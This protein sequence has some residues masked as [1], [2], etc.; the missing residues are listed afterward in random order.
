MHPI[1]DHWVVEG[2]VVMVEGEVV[3]VEGEALG[4]VEAVDVLVP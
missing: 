4:A 3:L 1:K 2:D